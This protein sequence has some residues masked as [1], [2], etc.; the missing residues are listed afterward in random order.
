[1][2]SH[3]PGLHPETSPPLKTDV[4][5]WT[6][7]WPV[8]KVQHGVQPVRAEGLRQRGQEFRLAQHPPKSKPVTPHMGALHAPQPCLWEDGVQGAPGETVGVTWGSSGREPGSRTDTE[9]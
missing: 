8:A 6:M 5:T 3:S 4:G 2:N 1:M 7:P 9:Q